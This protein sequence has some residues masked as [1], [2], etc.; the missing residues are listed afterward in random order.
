MFFRASRQRRGHDALLPHKMF[1]VM[2]GGALGLAGMAFEQGWLVWAAIGVLA[3]VM[4]IS[5]VQRRSAGESAES[6]ADSEGDAGI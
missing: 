1:L 2:I 3:I 5:L 6:R 4:V